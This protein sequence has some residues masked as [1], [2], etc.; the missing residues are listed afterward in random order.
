MKK[1]CPSDFYLMGLPFFG[2]YCTFAHLFDFV[3]HVDVHDLST[4]GN[5]DC[6]CDATRVLFA[7]TKKRDSNFYLD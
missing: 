6:E 5:S 7:P 2:N 3:C 1:T 4:T